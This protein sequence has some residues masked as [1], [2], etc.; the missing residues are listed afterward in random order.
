MF[1]VDIKSSRFFS[2]GLSK[3]KEFVHAV[4]QNSKFF[5]KKNNANQLDIPRTDQLTI[6]KLK[7]LT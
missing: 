6:S 3:K 1:S 2:V 4:G 5:E 7:Q